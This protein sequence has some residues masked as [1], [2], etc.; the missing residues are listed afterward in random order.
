MVNWSSSRGEFQDFEEILRE[1]AVM[2][3]SILE[4]SGMVLFKQDKELRYTWVYNPHPGFRGEEV[5]GKTDEDLLPEEDAAQLTAVKR[6]VLT[7]GEQTRKMVR[8]TIK[9]IPYYYDLS[10]QPEYD[11]DDQ[12]VGVLCCSVDVTHHKQLEDA[13][14]QVNVDS[15]ARERERT[16]E[17][18]QETD[19]R[20]QVQAELA[21]MQRH[22]MDSVE[23]ERTLLARELHDGPMQE[24]YAIMYRLA[25]WSDFHLEEELANDLKWVQS[26]LEK[27][28]RSLRSIARDLRPS[29]LDE[30][31]LEK[32][33]RAHLDN[34]RMGEHE[35]EVLSDLAMDGQT[36]P[37]Q[38][39]VALYRIYQ[40]AV[41]NV[42]RHARATRVHI[43]LRLDDGV[44]VLEVQDN[45]RGLQLPED[46]L[47]LAREGHLGLLGAH[48][49]AQAIGGEL[50]V[51]SKLGEGTLVRVI[52]PRED[53]HRA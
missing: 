31:G 52:V 34:F 12:I 35:L 16:Q 50:E 28:N 5:I 37:E 10:V 2:F 33:I 19:I 32:A 21:E 22:L 4:K 48:E 45:G 42:I 18:M 29:L 41:N 27:I 23:N 40:V 3:Q 38:V 26:K 39:R 7:S 14:Q 17:L 8:T 46:W 24:I 51:N 13:L 9:G 1:N 47:S 25:N 53:N 11:D 36:L 6:E 15:E 30:F 49:R 44:I 20:K 43:R